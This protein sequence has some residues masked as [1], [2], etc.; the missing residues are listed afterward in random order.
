VTGNWEMSQAWRDE[1]ADAARVGGGEV[2]SVG[3]VIYT[4][5]GA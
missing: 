1:D 4:R 5:A 2:S 3:G